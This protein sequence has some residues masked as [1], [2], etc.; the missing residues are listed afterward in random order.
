MKNIRQPR[1]EY[2]HLELFERHRSRAAVLV[3]YLFRVPQR[4]RDFFNIFYA[5]SVAK[6]HH[7]L[8][9]NSAGV[10]TVLREIV[11]LSFPL[12]Y[13]RIDSNNEQSKSY[14]FKCNHVQ[15]RRFLDPSKYVDGYSSQHVQT[16]S[17]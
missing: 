14:L 4:V 11:R 17:V 16:S 8:V 5:V 12:I 6:P 2:T 10:F 3:D 13:T 9:A 7:R 1:T 15:A